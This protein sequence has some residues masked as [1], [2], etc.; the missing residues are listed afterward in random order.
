MPPQ[1]KREAQGKDVH[2]LPGFGPK[3]TQALAAVGIHTI[4]QLKSSDLYEVYRK[5]KEK[6]PGTSLN[7]MY[8][9]IAAVESCDWREVH[10]TRR[11]EI[12]LRLDE[13]GI[14]PK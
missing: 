7:F 1:R 9:L 5:L 13:L 12:L 8:G 4:E 11:T 6:V 2:R 3:T 14:A 10:R